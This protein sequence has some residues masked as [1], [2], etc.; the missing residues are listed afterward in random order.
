[1][2]DVADAAAHL[3]WIAHASIV[4]RDPAALPHRSAPFPTAL[5]FAGY[6]VTAAHYASIADRL[7]TWGYAVIQANMASSSAAIT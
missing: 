7:A 2:H 4:G 1:M 5:M 6:G 3:A